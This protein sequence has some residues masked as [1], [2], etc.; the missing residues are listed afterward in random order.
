MPVEVGSSEDGFEINT[1]AE[2]RESEI[3]QTAPLTIVGTE[4]LFHY[5]LGIGSL[6]PNFK[7]VH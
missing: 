6:S 5:M 1:R 3:L 2:H 7:S 4:D